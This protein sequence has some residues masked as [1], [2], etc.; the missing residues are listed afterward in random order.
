MVYNTPNSYKAT[1]SA[2][3]KSGLIREIASLERGI[4]YYF[5]TNVSKWI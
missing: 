4:Y 1:H 2:M 5:T 3:K